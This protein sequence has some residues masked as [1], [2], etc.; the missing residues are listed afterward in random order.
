MTTL[1]KEEL[2]APD[3]AGEAIAGAA[4]ASDTMPEHPEALTAPSARTTRCNSED[5][6]A[7]SQGVWP[8]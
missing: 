8:F 5:G 3:L 1:Q 4:G 7:V 2:E 6:R